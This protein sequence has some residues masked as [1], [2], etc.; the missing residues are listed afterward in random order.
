MESRLIKQMVTKV[1]SAEKCN[2]LPIKGG[3]IRVCYLGE[4]EVY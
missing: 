2:S 1:I 4:S 3:G